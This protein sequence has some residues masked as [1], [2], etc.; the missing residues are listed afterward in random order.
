MERFFLSC[1]DGEVCQTMLFNLRHE[2]VTALNFVERENYMIFL[3]LNYSLHSKSQ[4]SSVCFCTRLR[5]I[6]CKSLYDPLNIFS[7]SS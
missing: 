2:S 3:M 4:L 7:F 6:L 5:S 1:T